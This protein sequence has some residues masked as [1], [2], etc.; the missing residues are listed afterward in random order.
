MFDRSATAAIVPNLSRNVH[1]ATAETMHGSVTLPHAELALVEEW[2]SHNDS[3]T[4]LVVTDRHRAAKFA[5]CDRAH[6]GH[7]K[8]AGIRGGKRF[9]L[10]WG[11][12]CH[13]R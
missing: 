4:R 3:C 5:L 13:R 11:T 1:A 10:S 6:D 12:P 2:H 7:A 9:S 8:T